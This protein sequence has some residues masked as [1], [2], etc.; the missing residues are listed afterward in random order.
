MKGFTLIEL[1]IATA[2]FVIIIGILGGI[3]G[4]IN[5]IQRRSVEIQK[6]IDN[7]RYALEVMAKA[8]R[9]SEINTTTSGSLINM[10]HPVK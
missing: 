9:M 10:T 6:A 1:I 5:K 4:Q 3:Y 2:I 8:I 7:T